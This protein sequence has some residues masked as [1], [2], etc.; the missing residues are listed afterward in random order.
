MRRPY[1]TRPGL[2][3]EFVG[4]PITDELATLPMEKSA[5]KAALGI[6]AQEPVLTLMPGSRP[7]EL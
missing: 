5:A 4:H 6:P 3:C 1:T 2:P 7:T